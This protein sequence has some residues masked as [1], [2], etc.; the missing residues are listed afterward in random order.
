M[1]P[2]SHFKVQISGP[3]VDL[4]SDN[5]RPPIAGLPDWSQAGYEKGK[6]L[7][8]S[9]KISTII[10]AAQLA[11]EYGVI[12]NDGIDDTDGLQRAIKENYG[13]PDAFTL[14]QLPAGTINLSH[15]VYFGSNWII[16]RGAGSDPSSGTVIEFHPDDNTKYDVITAN[17]ANWDVSKMTFSWDYII[18]DEDQTGM[19]EKHVRGTAGSGWLW[20]G[21]SIFRVG[22]DAIADK[23]QMP[24]NLAPP[25]RKDFFLGT[26]NYHW[27]NDTGKIKGYMADQ[28]RPIAGYAGTRKIYVD[29][30]NSSW[31]EGRSPGFD[32]WVAVPARSVDFDDWQ[33]RNQSYYENDFMYQDW[34]TVTNI[35]QDGDGTFIEVDHDLA[36]NVYPNSV[37]G[38]ADQMDDLT[39][40]TKVM[41]IHLSAHH[42]GIE[43]LY[44]TQ[45]M[46]GLSAAEAA[47]NYGNMAPESAMHGIVFRYAK[48][49]WVRNVRTFMT[50]S[51]PIAT[52]AARHIQIQD[53]YFDGA[54]NKGA[55]GNG[56]VRGS[57]VWDSLY[58]NNTLRNLRHFTFQWS[59]MRNVATLQNMTCDLNLHGGY[60][61]YN[62]LELNYVSV[63]YSHRAGNCLGRCGGEGGSSEGGT[64]APIYWSTGNKASKWSGATGPQNV[65]FRNYMIKAFAPGSS[66][67]DYLP[68]FSRD[69]SLSNTIWQFGWDRQTDFGSRYQHLSLDGGTNL[70]LDWANNE[71]Q[72]YDVD[73]AVGVNGQ[74]T[75]D[76][77][78]LFFRDVRNASGIVSFSSIAGYAYCL[79][80]VEPKVV[81]YYSGSAATRSCLP[82]HTN[83]IDPNTYTH[84]IFAYATLASD[85]TVSL[86]SAQQTQVQEIAAL[87]TKFPDFKV[88]IAV[89]G[90]GLGNDATPLATIATSNSAR[91]KFGTT[92][93]SL[94]ASVNA[95]GIDIEWTPCVGTRCISA[96]QFSTIATQVKTGIGA[97]KMLSLS[98]PNEFWYLSGVNTITTNLANIVEFI[99]IITHQ[100][101]PNTVDHAN[102]LPVIRATVA[103]AQASGMPP[104]K[105]LFG[106]PFYSRP[107]GTST[108]QSSCIGPNDL[109]QGTFPFYSVASIVY[110]GG[111]ESVIIEEDNISTWYD[112]TSRAMLLELQDGTIMQ[113]EVAE[114]VS[115]RASLSQDLCMGGVSVYTIDQDSDNNELAAALYAPGGLS[116]VYEDIVAAF[117][118]QAID[119]NGYL[120]TDGY[121]AFSAHLAVEYPF[122]TAADNYRLL[123]LAALDLQL[124]L[125]IR[126][127]SL[128]KDKDFSNDSFELYKKWETK[129]INYEL[130]NT[131]GL[132]REFFSCHTKIT[133]TSDPTP[134]HCPGGFL[135][136]QHMTDYR[137]IFWVLDDREGYKQYL[138]ET[139][140]IDLDDL[141]QGSFRVSRNRE[142]CFHQPGPPCPNPPCHSTL[143]TPL[144]SSSS[145][146]DDTLSRRS[147]HRRHR[148]ALIRSTTDDVNM[149]EKR[150]EGD[151]FEPPSNCYTTWSGIWLIDPEETFAN[152]G[153]VIR[154]YMEATDAS[155]QEYGNSIYN[156]D[157]QAYLI[158]T[159]S[160]LLDSVALGNNTIASM[161]AYTE[162][163]RWAETLQDSVDQARA[164]TSVWN[165][166]LDVF[167]GLLTVLP[168]VGQ[169]S[170]VA[171]VAR[172]AFASMKGLAKLGTASRSL[173]ADSAFFRLAARESNLGLT[174]G[175]ASIREAF[176]TSGAYFT[177]AR[178]G[179]SARTV[180]NVMT[181]CVAETLGDIVLD[182]L[183]NNIPL[184]SPFP[185]RT[186]DAVATIGAIAPIALNISASLLPAA[187]IAMG[188]LPRA[189][190]APKQPKPTCF[191][192][193]QAAKELKTDYVKFCE[194]RT[195]KMLIPLDIRTNDLTQVYEGTFLECKTFDRTGDHLLEPDEVFKL[196]ASILPG[197]KEKKGVKP[198]PYK[199]SQQEVDD[200]CN[201]LDPNSLA[202]VQ[203]HL[204]SQNNLAGLYGA[205]TKGKRVTGANQEKNAILGTSTGTFKIV[206]E[207]REWGFEIAESHMLQY[208]DNRHIAATGLD[209]TFLQMHN[210]IQASNSN[211]AKNAWKKV[212]E[213]TLIGKTA[214]STPLL[215]LAN[216]NEKKSTD[217]MRKFRQGAGKPLL[218]PTPVRIQVPSTPD[219]LRPP[220]PKQKRKA[221][222]V[223]TTSNDPN[224]P[225]GASRRKRQRTDDDD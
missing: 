9:S 167:L 60:E 66:Q 159:L 134:V 124:K 7:P 153:D 113:S 12:P 21:R 208:V 191:F 112:K 39:Y 4:T 173:K 27:R 32:V 68:Y 77:T 5:R 171:T 56:Y 52:E 183:L 30:Q 70:L 62:L 140:D 197:H 217:T 20:P 190:A 73:P 122:F 180:Q 13:L 213:H 91:T 23:F 100:D 76:R 15:T 87:K 187:S 35:G 130:T 121:D 128:L 219:P 50:G 125:S 166:L 83:S 221:D 22:T 137:E 63:P 101:A 119:Q 51:H 116:P 2:L 110:G 220:P 31:T 179:E 93:S 108:L 149:H 151:P 3:T 80:K 103:R 224:N 67:E 193:I 176:R 57:R 46:P 107:M 53:S 147:R 142:S 158:S 85:G 109:G 1:K 186:D 55:G 195:D 120:R 135:D 37:A 118:I 44:M 175:S 136:Y 155:I 89:G 222:S 17:G 11:S 160:N 61:A 214:A 19:G 115:L 34:F 38:G 161:L 74:R 81:G 170:R 177:R 48:H 178:L 42:I 189:P 25:N 49:C 198:S 88:F 194:S 210:K 129:A 84:V 131:T 199:L 144:A 164:R 174:T 104:S 126:L 146:Q 200:I 33:V 64:W 192:Q 209:G 225:C 132:A 185:R 36:W 59:S 215:T 181:E 218:P 98:T 95:D 188:L 203:G 54:W 97:T 86:T 79:G 106:I 216:N 154:G 82:W 90:W 16:L 206:P 204:N 133:D 6:P 163:V 165:I 212:T 8:D 47:Q 168:G 18:P 10:T 223:A 172:S 24:Y 139:M 196:F 150:D 138:N 127:S 28:T 58:Y 205:N 182:T 94:L 152:P 99:S 72:S 69:G 201:A 29:A 102:D 145:S 202:T 184:S 14:I 141:I 45:P 75:D 143:R 156:T 65:F 162:Q 211:A 111:Y 92:A 105:M 117:G 207:A 157:S 78:S 114:S 40:F 41:P 169:I 96:S 148:R 26:A 71:R 123:I 43:D